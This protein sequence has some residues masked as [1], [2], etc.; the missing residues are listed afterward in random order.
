[1]KSWWRG[2]PARAWITSFRGFARTAGRMPAAPWEAASATASGA[3][4]GAG[5]AAAISDE[6]ATAAEAGHGHRSRFSD[7]DQAAPSYLAPM[8]PRASLRVE[9]SP[10]S[11][12][13]SALKRSWVSRRDLVSASAAATTA[14]SASADCP[15][16]RA[17]TA[18][19]H[20]RGLPYSKRQIEVPW[21]CR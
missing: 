3:A 11:L 19:G 15:E 9:G 13:W 12:V 1:M 5:S 4:S 17:A 8:S 10:P 20:G 14:P 16:P 2:L 7:T 21:G 6:P 18:P